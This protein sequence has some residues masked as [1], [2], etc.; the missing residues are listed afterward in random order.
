MTDFLIVGLSVGSFLLVYGV[1][2]LLVSAFESHVDRLGASHV[3]GIALPDRDRSPV[4]GWLSR[5][6]VLGWSLAR[7]TMGARRGRKGRLVARFRRRKFEQRL[8][9][10]QHP[11]LYALKTLTKKS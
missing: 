10:S 11:R 5:W 1:V 2:V 4:F 8:Y 9:A 7:R 6:C 3:G